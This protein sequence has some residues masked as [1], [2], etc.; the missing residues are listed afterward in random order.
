MSHYLQ[1]CAHRMLGDIYTGLSMHC[2]FWSFVLM[3][4]LLFSIQAMIVLHRG[5]AAGVL[6]RRLV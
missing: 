4:S 6:F 3:Q 1:E 5:A 2:P